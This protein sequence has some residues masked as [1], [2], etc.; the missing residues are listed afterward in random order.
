M[1][2]ELDKELTD[3]H[4]ATIFEF[5]HQYTVWKISSWPNSSIFLQLG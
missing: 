3:K 5:K 1:W 4:E 2:L